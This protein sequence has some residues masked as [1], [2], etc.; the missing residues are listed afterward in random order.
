MS[1]ILKIKN[2]FPHSISN[3]KTLFSRFL[4]VASKTADTH[5]SNT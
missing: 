2:Q 5:Q 1:N 4:Y 3:L